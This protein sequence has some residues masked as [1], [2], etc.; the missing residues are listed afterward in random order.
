[1]PEILKMS[2]G[3]DFEVSPRVVMAACLAE[4]EMDLARINAHYAHGQLKRRSDELRCFDLQR[5]I[6]RLRQQIAVADEHA[7]K[8]ASRV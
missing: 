6:Q 7:A 5:R 4:A 1:M 8:E 2:H 3:P